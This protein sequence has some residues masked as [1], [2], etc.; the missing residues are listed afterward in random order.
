M[1]GHLY[2]VAPLAK[3]REGSAPVMHRRSS[4][5]GCVPK[6]ERIISDN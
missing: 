3:G 1:Q 5:P 4:I 6:H 2:P